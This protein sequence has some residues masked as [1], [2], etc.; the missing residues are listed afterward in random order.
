MS[1][2]GTVCAFPLHDDVSRNAAIALYALYASCIRAQFRKLL[3]ELLSM[4][5]DVELYEHLC[6][7]GVMR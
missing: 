5:C 6:G 2:S 4:W 7:N 3:V 1:L